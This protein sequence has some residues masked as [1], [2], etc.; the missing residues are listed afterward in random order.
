MENNSM[1]TGVKDMILSSSKWARIAA[2][3]SIINIGLGFAQMFLGT[4]KG[5]PNIISSL[6]PFIISG[7]ISLVMAVNLLNFSKH[8][9][10]GAELGDKAHLSKSFSH[11]KVYFTIIGVI[12]VILLSLL[13]LGLLIFTI[14]LIS[15]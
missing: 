2:I 8:V 12:F 11:L 15:K 13:A 6:L 14:A 3:F 5:D 4:I 10:I 7:T 9:K 1:N